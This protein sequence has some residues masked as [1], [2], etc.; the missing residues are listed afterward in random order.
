MTGFFGFSPLTLLGEELSFL[1]DDFTALLS[2]EVEA[3]CLLV[4]VGDDL[5]DKFSLEVD[6]LGKG[7]MGEV[8]DFAGFSWE[9]LL[10]RGFEPS[11]PS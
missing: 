1:T 5:V 10:A 2:F 11:E 6:C 7:L 4:S 9:L 3:L 8:D